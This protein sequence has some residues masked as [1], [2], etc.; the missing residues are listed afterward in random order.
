[1]LQGLL[2]LEFL[3]FGNLS[4]MFATCTSLNRIKLDFGEIDFQF[5]NESRVPK[6]DHITK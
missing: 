6:K 3:V 2:Y 5:K 1:M 4:F